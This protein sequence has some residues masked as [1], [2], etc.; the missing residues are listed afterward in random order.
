MMENHVGREGAGRTLD[1]VDRLALGAAPTFAA[2][3]ALTALS[4]DAHSSM[5]CTQGGWQTLVG[6]MAPMYGVPAPPPETPPEQAP[7]DQPPSDSG[8]GPRP[9]YGVPPPR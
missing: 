7:P 8:G 3:A 2:M 9:M 4:G 5:L 1:A 6:E